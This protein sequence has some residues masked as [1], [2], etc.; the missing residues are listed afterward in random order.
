M[1][2]VERKEG[3]DANTVLLEETSKIRFLTK[4]KN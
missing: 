2:R 4:L 3:N 1:A